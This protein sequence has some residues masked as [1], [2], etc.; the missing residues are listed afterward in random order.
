M[1]DFHALL[2]ERKLLEAIGGS[3]ALLD[4]V[5]SNPSGTQADVYASF[6][7]DAYARRQAIQIAGDIL[8]GAQ[9]KHIDIGTTL[10]E[11]N[12]KIEELLFDDGDFS[13][14]VDI[15]QKKKKEANK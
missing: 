8:F 6:I 11:A 9:Q 10:D 3:D 13:V 5:E 4:I 12:G 14:F 1:A 2:E 15:F 7:M